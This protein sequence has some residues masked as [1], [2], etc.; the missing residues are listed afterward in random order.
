MPGFLDQIKVNG[1]KLETPFTIQQV[2]SHLVFG[3]ISRH[4]PLAYAAWVAAAANV[5]GALLATN[6]PWIE[7]AVAVAESFLWFFLPF[8][9]TRM[10]LRQQAI[11]VWMGVKGTL[12]FC[13]FMMATLGAGVAFQRGQ[14]D[15]WPLLCLGIIWIPLIEFLPRVAPH[16]KYVTVARLLLSIPCVIVGVRS[17][18]WH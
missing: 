14:S 11:V 5:I 1:S 16:Q 13:A 10:T 15:A 3:P 8:F 2:E 4:F 9:L 18:Y 12:G 7:Y 17:G 6:R